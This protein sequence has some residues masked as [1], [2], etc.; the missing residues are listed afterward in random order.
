VTRP[1]FRPLLLAAL[2]LLPAAASAQDMHASHP[3]RTF[4]MVRNQVDWSNP[5]DVDLW[6][7]ESDAWIGG[8]TNKL[9][10]RS[11]GE[12]MD[13]DVEQASLEVLYSRN[14]A[15]FWDVQAGVRHEF[16]PDGVSHLVAGV[17]GLA[18]YQFETEAF[19]YLSEDGD[20]GL[21]F[22]QALDLHL[23]QR[24]ILEP[25]VEAGFQFQDVPERGLGSGLTSVGVS[26]QLRYEITRKVAPYVEV[27]YERLLGDTADLAAAAGHDDEETSL[28]IGLRSW[29]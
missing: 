3:D 22:E 19:A 28:R 29:F 4:W 2:V 9:W 15:T 18:P 23:T 17:Q 12:I 16:E 8:D 27:G 26:A 25:E 10:L 20:L 5:D 6:T 14:V 7:W 13:G 1:G 24:L 11:D 21:R